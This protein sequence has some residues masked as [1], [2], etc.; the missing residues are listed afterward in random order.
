[1]IFI[2]ENDVFKEPV[3]KYFLFFEENIWQNQKNKFIF[4][5]QIK[6]KT[7]KHVKHTTTY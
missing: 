1:L 4:A 2:G 5:V 7:T 6:L 3:K